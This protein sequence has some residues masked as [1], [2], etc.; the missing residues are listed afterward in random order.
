MSTTVRVAKLD[1]WASEA[2]AADTHGAD[3]TLVIHQLAGARKWAYLFAS[4]PWAAG[5]GV[6]VISAT[7]R[8]F[9]TKAVGTGGTLQAHRIEQQWNEKAIAWKSRPAVAT[10]LAATKAVANGTAAGTA[11]DIDVTAAMQEVAD[12]ALYFGFRL[13]FDPAAGAGPLSIASSDLRDPAR[14]PSLIITWSSP[15][16]RPTGL[17]PSGGRFVSSRKPVLSWLFGDVL[18]PL[19]YQSAFEV[20]ISSVDTFTST[21]YASGQIAGGLSQLALAS[22]AYAGLPTDGAVRYWRVRVWDD[23]GEASEWADPAAI[24]YAP[25]GAVV[26]STPAAPTSD[27]RPV[28]TWAFTPPATPAGEAAVVQEAYR[29]WIEQA[30]SAAPIFDSG[31]ITGTD[32]QWSPP[33]SLPSLSSSYTARVQILDSL[34]REATSGAPAAAAASKAFTYAAGGGV[35]DPS[36]LTA[37]VIDGYAVRLQWTRPTKPAHWILEADGV[38]VADEI[39]VTP[40][41]GTSYV[42]IWYGAFPRHLTSLKLHAA[43]I[44]GGAI[45]ASPGAAVSV[46]T[47]P[48]GIW[49][50]DPATGDQ[51]HVAGRDDLSAQIGEESATYSRIGERAPVI[52]TEIVR[53]YEGS[54]SGLLVEWAGQDPRAAKDLLLQ[55]REHGAELR[56]VLGDLNLPVQIWGLTANPTPAPDDD[57]FAVGMSFAQVGEWDR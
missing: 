13:I 53:G 37:T 24:R 15:P 33:S 19:A 4:R 54:V 25:L 17:K 14:H 38:I 6:T 28:L 43:E 20:Q 16:D 36:S 31:L 39:D 34:P 45:A 1:A 18:D 46:T 7:L 40:S 11:I 42:W 48:V 56:L 55:L 22:T 52:V 10:T 27:V 2:R 41:G 26:L 9:T 21:E 49:I 3:P 8:I 23:S 5:A 32:L 12:G 51:V 57:R 30:G 47:D 29:A 44:I 35:V 50:V